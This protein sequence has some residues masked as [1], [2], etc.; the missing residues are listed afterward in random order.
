MFAIAFINAR[1]A[2]QRALLG[3]DARDPVVPY[4][5]KRP[6]LRRRGTS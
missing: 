5:E 6:R 2:M 4:R 3:S 1:Y